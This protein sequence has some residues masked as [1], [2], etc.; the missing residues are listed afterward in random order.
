M[1]PS[2]PRIVELLCPKDFIYIGERGRNRTFNLLIKSRA[3]G[4]I[5]S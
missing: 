3:E 5:D 4:L 2:V 1:Y